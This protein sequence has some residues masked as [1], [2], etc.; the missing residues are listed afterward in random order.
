MARVTGP[1]MSIDASGTIYKTL[2]ASISKGRNYIKGYTKPTYTNTDLQAAQR[3]KM[4]AAVLEW[5]GL[6]ALPPDPQVLGD[7]L[8]KSKWDAFGATCVRP[9]S[10]YNAFVKAYIDQGTGPS[11]PTAPFVGPVGIHR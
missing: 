6:D 2:T 4:A 10:G 5:Q 9:L 7:E 11:I 1:F 8:Y 3:A